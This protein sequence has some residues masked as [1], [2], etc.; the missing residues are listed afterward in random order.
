MK[1]LKF[2]NW[3]LNEEQTLSLKK[4]SLYVQKIIQLNDALG[5]RFNLDSEDGIKTAG[6]TRLD[7]LKDVDKAIKGNTFYLGIEDPVKRTSIDVALTQ[8]NA[9][10]S[11]LADVMVRL[12]RK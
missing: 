6:S 1:H 5:L 11:D 8:T 4:K 10:I 7:T 3:L 12:E 2:Y 9:K